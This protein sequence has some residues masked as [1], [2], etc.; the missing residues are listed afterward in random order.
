MNVLCITKCPTGMIQ[1]YVAAE[2]L[3]TEGKALGYDIA[4]ET[5][6]TK[7]IENRFTP[8]QVD[9]ADYI[10][11][12]SDVVVGENVRFGNKK[13]VVVSLSDA[14]SNTKAILETLEAK[15]MSYDEAKTAYRKVFG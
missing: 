4:V 7:G 15:A 6:G 14:I 11:I 12:A 10:L 8:Q 3:E 13:L 9:D 2:K 5:H 1:T